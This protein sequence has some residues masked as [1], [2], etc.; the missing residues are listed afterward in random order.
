MY[1]ANFGGYLLKFTKTNTTFPN[2]LIAAD[3]FSSTPLQRTEIKAWRDNNNKLHRTTSPNHKT[4]IVLKTTTLSLSEARSIMQMLANAYSNY[5]QRKL[6]VQYWDDEK[7]NYR[8]M[9]AY[10]PDITFGRTKITS[11]NIE[12]SGLEITFIEY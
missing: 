2:N 5:Q 1:G 12:Y 8:T 9:T 6:N 10:I 7:M 4:K 11:T 3:G